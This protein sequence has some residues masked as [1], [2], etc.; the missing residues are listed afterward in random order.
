MTVERKNND[1]ERRSLSW[2]PLFV[3]SLDPDL[4]I[5]ERFAVGATH[6][7]LDGLAECGPRKNTATA[8]KA[9]ANTFVR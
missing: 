4:S 2:P 8:T 6:N 7:A 3:F 1:R 5:L 9:A